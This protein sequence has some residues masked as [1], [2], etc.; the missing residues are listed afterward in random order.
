MDVF[1][2]IDIG[3]LWQNRLLA[4]GF[5]KVYQIGKAYRNEGSSPTHLQEFTN[6][7]FYWAY[8]DYH[9]GMKMIKELYRKIATEVYGKTKF[10]IGQHT[11]DLADEW[12]EIDYAKHILEKTGVDVFSTSE[13]ILKNKLIELNVKWDGDGRE[14]LTDTLWK[15]CRKQISGPAFLINHPTFTSALSKHNLDGKT[16][17]R[18]QPVIAGAEVGNGFSELNDP[19]IQKANFEVQKKLIEAGDEE[20]MMPDFSFVEML[21]HG[22]PPAFGY[23]FGERMFAFFEGVPIREIQMFPLVKPLNEN[24]DK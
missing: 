3:E 20:A 8:A 2:R 10:T 19:R 24:N 4:G 22:M 9:D 7:E 14:R 11:F 6:C 18:F 5:E 12:I 13:D 17:Q 1:M 16:V 21:E 23:G 15:Y